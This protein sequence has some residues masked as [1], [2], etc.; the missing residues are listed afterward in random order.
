MKLEKRN[1]YDWQIIFAVLVFLTV[2]YTQSWGDDKKKLPTSLPAKPAVATKPALPG[3][4]KPRGTP[5]PPISGKTTGHPAPPKQPEKTTTAKTAKPDA[6]NPGGKKTEDT[7]KGQ[8][9]RPSI[10]T[11]SKQS[12][13]RIKYERQRTTTETNGTRLAKDS[14][15]K[16]RDLDRPGMHV[17]HDLRGGS[18]FKAEHNNRQIVGMGHN[19]GYMQ[20]K[21]Y[22]HNGHSYFQRTYIVNGRSY[23]VA[24][25]S[26]SYGGVAYYS[27]APAYY[28][29]PAF[30]GWAYSPWAAPVAYN[31]GWAGNPWYSGYGYY[32][33]P[34]PVYTSASLWLTDYLLAENLQLAYASAAEAAASA[35]APPSDSN[36]AGQVALSPEVKQ[37]VSEEVKR[38]LEADKLASSQG[39][40]TQTGT[41]QANNDAPPALDS[42]QK[43]FIVAS[44]LDLVDD[45]GHECAVTPGDV[46]LRIGKT[47]DAD[48][49]ITV[50]VESSKQG[51]CPV[52]T[53]SE[54][55]VS[56]L[57]EM[58]NQFR[59]KLDSGLK[60]LAA[61]QGKNGLPAAPDT[62]TSEGEVGQ[63]APDMNAATEITNQQKSAD[64]MEQQAAR[65][66][67][68]V[69]SQNK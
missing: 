24:Y 58:H 51:D 47:P 22:D 32:F 20:R 18:T 17:H 28:Y 1:F 42:A 67:P 3:L 2:I 34:Y 52:D 39:A 14:H 60:T 68:A 5:Q 25:R 41:K 11:D 10:K 4:G 27:Y 13:P 50:S 66:T 65:T 59:E 62:G 44:T 6:T 29:H 7:R 37:M 9:P 12:G 43:I 45:S 69:A 57:Q 19:S 40:Q 33:T 21:F 46:L 15:G 49:K 53:S 64:Q 61:N 54:V 56:D 55:A 26:Y 38:Q 31:W 36:V 16:I 48:N 30:Y 63:P 35:Q 8:D 23:A